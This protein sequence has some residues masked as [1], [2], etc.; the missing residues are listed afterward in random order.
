MV[1]KFFSDDLKNIDF[2][3]LKEF[4]HFYALHLV[5]FEICHMAIKKPLSEMIEETIDRK[6]LSEIINRFNNSEK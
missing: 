2:K 4:N 3:D 6:N 1:E 5:V